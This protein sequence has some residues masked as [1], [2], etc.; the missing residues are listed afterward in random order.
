MKMALNAL[1]ARRI[2]VGL[3]HLPS[4]RGIRAGALTSVLQLLERLPS[5]I[6]HEGIGISLLPLTALSG[7][8]GLKTL[9]EGKAV[10]VVDH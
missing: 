6:P 10:K 1:S 7:G 8:D 3:P 2:G 4:H 9:C 5:L